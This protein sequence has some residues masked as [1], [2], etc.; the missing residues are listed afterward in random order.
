[1]ILFALHVNKF[2]CV[3][4]CDCFSFDCLLLETPLSIGINN[5]SFNCCG[6]G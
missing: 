1:M 3:L 5:K 6:M 4:N 2:Y